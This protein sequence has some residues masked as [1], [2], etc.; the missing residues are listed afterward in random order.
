LWCACRVCVSVSHQGHARR[1][2]GSE[3]W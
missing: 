3:W 1:W 2:R